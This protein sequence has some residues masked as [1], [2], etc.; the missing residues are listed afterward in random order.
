[1]SLID[2]EAFNARL[3]SVK[4][5]A[6]L[7]LLQVELS[8]ETSECV[9]KM[10]AHAAASTNVQVA[11]PESAATHHASAL[12]AVLAAATEVAPIP[13]RVTGQGLADMFTILEEQ[14]RSADV[15]YMNP[16]DFADVRKFG[17]EMFDYETRMAVIRTG[18]MGS[19]YGAAVMVST[20]VPAGWVHAASLAIGNRPLLAIKA[21]VD[22]KA[23][24]RDSAN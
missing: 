5:V 24:P 6:D 1:M 22:R 17:R 21:Q 11:A 2:T 10:A 14:N 7:L 8:A 12:P 15:V 20:D 16:R 4:T 23:K 19:V 18:M 13:Y 9:R 3:G